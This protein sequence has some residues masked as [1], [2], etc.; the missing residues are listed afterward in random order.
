MIK[1]AFY[2]G[3]GNYLDKIIRWRTSSDTSHVELIVGNSMFSS[4][5]RDGGVRMRPLTTNASNWRIVD[6]PNIKN[7]AIYEFYDQ[8]RGASYDW[9]G[10]VVG[11]GAAVDV[12]SKN[13]WFCSEWCAHALGYEQ[14]WRFTPA[15]LEVVLNNTIL[16]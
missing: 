5:P 4:S 6:I 10:A 13:K 12:Q 14:G 2:I 16:Y 9:I 7:D 15:N 8:T 11:A 3:K 1:A